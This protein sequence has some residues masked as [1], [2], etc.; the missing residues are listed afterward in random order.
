M[1]LAPASVPLCSHREKRWFRERALSGPLGQPGRASEHARTAAPFTGATA[2][3][4]K[5]EVVATGTSAERLSPLGR[6]PGRKSLKNHRA[7]GTTTTATATTPVGRV[8][9]R[10]RVS[11]PLVDPPA[12]LSHRPTARSARKRGG[13]GTGR[14][15][16]RLPPVRA[17][18]TGRD[19]GA[20]A[21]LAL[22]ANTAG[23]SCYTVPGRLDDPP[24]PPPPPSLRGLANA[25][26]RAF[27]GTLRSAARARCGRRGAAPAHVH[28]PRETSLA[29][30]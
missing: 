8:F 20:R 2:Q 27:A 6:E 28:A 15:L 22:A 5:I 23:P 21:S 29:R 11:R 12:P 25:L 10:T 26:S 18:P 13:C 9:V 3:R 1:Y 30:G 4:K 24:P 19:P 16:C 7:T 14:G 17:R